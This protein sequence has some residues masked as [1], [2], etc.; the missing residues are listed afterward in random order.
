MFGEFKVRLRR[1]GRGFFG[2]KRRA[3]YLSDLKLMTE[4]S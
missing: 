1:V 3:E 4:Q 2:L